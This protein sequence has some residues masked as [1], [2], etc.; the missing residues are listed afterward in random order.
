MHCCDTSTLSWTTSWSQICFK[1]E[2]DFQG[3]LAGLEAEAGVDLLVH[4][5][6][7]G[8]AVDTNAPGHDPDDHT[9]W[10]SITPLPR[11]NAAILSRRIVCHCHGTSTV[12]LGAEA[13]MTQQ[14]QLLAN[15]DNAKD[16]GR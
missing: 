13:G 16:K 5:A 15:W 4:Y 3:Y 1:N 10:R 7:P 8:A 9:T 12:S 2:A 11:A 14:E 6:R